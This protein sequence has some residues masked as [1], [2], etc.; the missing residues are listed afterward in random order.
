MS[1]K[2]ISGWLKV[3]IILMGV[4]CF[5]VHSALSLIFLVSEVDEIHTMRIPWLIF[6]WSTAIPMIPALIFSWKTASN[7]GRDESFSMANAVNLH[8]IALC[9]G[10]DSLIVLLGGIILL[11]M[12]CSHPS[13]MIVSLII[14]AIGIAILVAAEGL[15]QLI[16]RAAN[17][18]SEAE[19]T[20]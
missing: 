15:S 1:V 19:L 4:M 5:C 20:I 6:I 2:K 9:S 14:V 17:L 18:Q 13:V 7:I 8:K 11:F 10:A 3:A 16:K 12:N